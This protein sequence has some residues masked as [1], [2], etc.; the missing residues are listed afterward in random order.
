MLSFQALQ[1]ISR[2]WKTLKFSY[3]EKSIYLYNKLFCLSVICLKTRGTHFN[4][5]A[6]F[7]SQTIM[8]RKTQLFSDKIGLLVLYFSSPICCSFTNWS[9]TDCWP[10][11]I[12]LASLI[13]GGPKVHT[14]SGPVSP[15]S[16]GPCIL[17]PMA[18]ATHMTTR[19]RSSPSSPRSS[20][21]TSRE[22]EERGPA[23]LESGVRLWNGIEEILNCCLKS[24][25]S[26]FFVSLSVY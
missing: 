13:S 16:G 1:N 20:T 3:I 24:M 15:T 19:Q 6:E 7:F 4:L 17:D 22:T 21:T 2:N 9:L 11:I 12:G 18:P 25:F 23:I 10:C 8:G 14:I 5:S 26:V